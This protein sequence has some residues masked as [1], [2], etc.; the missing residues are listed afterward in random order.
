M[1]GDL[2]R[3]FRG[4]R[5]LRLALVF[6]LFFVFMGAAWLWTRFRADPHWHLVEFAAF[7]LI[8][9]F[10]V[11]LA[12]R[13]WAYVAACFIL[14]AALGGVSEL[15]LTIDGARNRSY[16]GIYTVKDLPTGKRELVHGTTLH[17]LQWLDP[18]R[19]TQ[20]TSYYGGTRESG[21]TLLAAD[22]LFGPR[23]Q[24]A[25]SASA[26]AHWPATIARA[27]SGRSSRS[28]PRSSRIRSAASSLS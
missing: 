8:I 12:A 24:S 27:S 14:L 17:G 20:P 13:R 11:T 3:W 7:A 9:A 6:L 19:A 1:V 25:S 28:I 15:Q 21:A 22:Q 2:S 16:F 26:P 23:A 10:A 18:A 5:S 4:E